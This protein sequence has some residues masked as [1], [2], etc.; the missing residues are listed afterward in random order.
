MRY[1]RIMDQL[2]DAM[3]ANKQT[4]VHRLEYLAQ[5]EAREYREVKAKE[6]TASEQALRGVFGDLLTLF[7][8]IR[9]KTN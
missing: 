6:P 8:T 9:N 1:W 5:W 4:R 3:L 2:S 7:P